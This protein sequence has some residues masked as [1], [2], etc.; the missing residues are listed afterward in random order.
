MT[1]SAYGSALTALLV[2][3]AL[4]LTGCQ[5]SDDSS[6]S[7]SGAPTGEE[8]TPLFDGESLSGWRNPYDWGEARVG[9]EMRGLYQMEI[10]KQNLS[11][12]EGKSIY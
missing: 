5:S 1:R 8:W 4:A 12:L 2:A 6:P 11:L 10:Y 9:P 3:A 7:S